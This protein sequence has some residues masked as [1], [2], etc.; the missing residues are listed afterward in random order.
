MSFAFEIADGAWIEIDQVGTVLPGGGEL[1]EDVRVS[2][3]FV[4][5]LPPDTRA[6]RGFVEVVETEAP[7][8]WIGWTVEDVGGLP[9][10][11]YQTAP[12]A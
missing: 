7:E 4:V 11:V 2:Q 10:R 6:A 8:G 12:E 3:A 9:T 1:G 5:S